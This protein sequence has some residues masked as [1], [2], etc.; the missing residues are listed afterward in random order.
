MLPSLHISA[1]AI[2]LACKWP[3]QTLFLCGCLFAADCFFCRLTAV[4]GAANCYQLDITAE[5]AYTNT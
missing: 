1:K 4:N 5:P 2:H 3:F